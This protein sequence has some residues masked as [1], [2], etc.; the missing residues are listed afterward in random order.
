MCIKKIKNYLAN[1]PIT[2]NAILNHLT[3][4]AVIILGAV[5]IAISIYA[6]SC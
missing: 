6:K 2:R 3:S 5:L 1:N 4:P